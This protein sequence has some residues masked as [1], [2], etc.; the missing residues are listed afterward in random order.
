MRLR[1]RKIPVEQHYCPLKQKE[2]QQQAAKSFQ[3]AELLLILTV[4][5]DFE[6]A[7]NLDLD[8]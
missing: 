4:V 5:A 8:L 3:Q 6:A 2:M 7:P 1:Q